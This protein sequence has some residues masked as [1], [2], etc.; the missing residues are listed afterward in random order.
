MSDADYWFNRE[1]CFSCGGELAREK[2]SGAEVLYCK[3]CGVV[4]AAIEV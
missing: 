1:T 4:N 3:T 2:R